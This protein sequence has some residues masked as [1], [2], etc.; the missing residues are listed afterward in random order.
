MANKKMNWGNNLVTRATVS[1]GKSSGRWVKKRQ[2][3]G[4]EDEFRDEDDWKDV[5]FWKEKNEGLRWNDGL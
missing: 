1:M 3:D 5:C 2:D 4:E